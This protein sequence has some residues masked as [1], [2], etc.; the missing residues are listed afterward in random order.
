MALK[1]IKQQLWRSSQSN[2]S[3]IAV[4]VTPDLSMALK[5]LKQSV[6]LG[7]QTRRQSSHGL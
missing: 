7:E 3:S 2:N 6:G 1:P 5:P 4:A